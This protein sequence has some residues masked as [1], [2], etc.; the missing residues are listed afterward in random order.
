MTILTTV[1]ADVAADLV[2][3]ADSLVSRELARPEVRTLARGKGWRADL[4]AATAAAGWLEVLVGEEHGGLGLGLGAAAGLFSVIGRRLAPGPYL[5]HIVMVPAVY[6]HAS[7]SVRPHLDRARAGEELVVLADPAASGGQGI[8]LAD[9]ALSG[10]AGLVR[11]GSMAGGFVVIASDPGRGAALAFIDA[12]APGVTVTSRDSFDPTCVVADV[13]FDRVPVR[14]DSIIPAPG[15]VIG[16]LRATLRLMI[17]TELTGL[18]RHLLDASVGYARIREQFGR[19]IGSFQSVQH[20]LAEMAT[21]VLGAE[22]F[23]AECAEQFQHD[24]PEPNLP[25]AIAIKGFA[26]QVARQVG[27]SALQVHGGI[28]FT[29]EFEDNRWFLHALTLQGL[30]GDETASFREVGRTLLAPH[31]VAR[32][33]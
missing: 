28:A 17:A 21:R 20:I 26:A 3:A 30:Y 14:G 8:V 32:E 12:A 19:P 15:T 27:E 10:Q 7:A 18:A 24:W 9:G 29:E 4:W 6:P 2:Q 11:Y 16:L 1:P 25:D 22:A 5:D 33:D 23:T 13:R 31:G